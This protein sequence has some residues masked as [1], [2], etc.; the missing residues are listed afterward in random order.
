MAL[1]D[2]VEGCTGS[3]LRLL[4]S[5]SIRFG[6][7]AAGELVVAEV[8]VFHGSEIFY[9]GRYRAGQL[10]VGQDQLLQ[11]PQ[12]VQLLGNAAVELVVV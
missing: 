10:V 1:A 2:L 11:C 5:A 4:M 8:E 7:H 6:G 3:P 12:P 9:L